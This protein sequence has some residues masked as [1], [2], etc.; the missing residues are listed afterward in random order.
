MQRDP[1]Q[2]VDGTPTDARDGAQRAAFARAW[3]AG[4]SAH[5]GVRH[6][7][8]RRESGWSSL[9]NALIGAFAA[10]LVLVALWSAW[11]ASAVGDAES[12]TTWA[13]PGKAISLRY[14]EGW[15]SAE[16]GEGESVHAFFVRSTWVRIHVIAGPE[17]A[18]IG[19]WPGATGGAAPD[20]YARLA[21]VHAHSREY[22]QQLFGEMREGQLGRTIIGGR[23][24]VWSEFHYRGGRLEGRDEPMTGYRATVLGAG[25]GMVIAAVS[26]ERSWREFRP[27]A[28]DVLRSARLGTAAAVSPET[29]GPSSRATRE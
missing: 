19:S 9:T 2:S 23:P 1:E 22:W 10:L 29:D 17:V 8:A 27:I 4:G 11:S 6:P 3:A 14:P 25:T 28:L 16:F 18:R 5:P 12:W 24:A 7:R 21:Q 13:P 15:R 20:A 26:P